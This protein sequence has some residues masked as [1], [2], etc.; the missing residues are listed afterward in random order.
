[1]TVLTSET[2]TG[3]D[4]AAWPA[5]WDTSN[6]S[7]SSTTTIQGNRGRCTTSGVGSFN[8][9]CLV[10]LTPTPA[11]TDFDATIDLTLTDVNESFPVIRWRDD[12]ASPQNGWQIQLLT[13]SNILRFGKIR[14]GNSAAGYPLTA[15]PT[16]ALN[17]TWRF[18]IRCSGGTVQAKY[19]K[20]ASASEPGPWDFSVAD[21]EFANN[22]NFALQFTEGSAAAARTC[23]WDNLTISDAD[24]G[25]PNPMAPCGPTVHAKW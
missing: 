13:A 16:F 8:G 11:F 12:F 1:M 9:F 14:A 15:T 18:R 4:G 22:K 10:R 17:D 23:E 21:P 6:N 25:P 24:I 19:W 7:A 20:P 2:W 3:S 5:Q